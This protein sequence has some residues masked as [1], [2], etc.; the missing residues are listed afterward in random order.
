MSSNFQ[1]VDRAC[2]VFWGRV[3]RATGAQARSVGIFR[4]IY[5][6]Y[7]LALEAPSFTFIDEAPRAFFDPPVLSL[8]FLLDGFP[9]PPFFRILDLFSVLAL[10]LVTIGY[11]TRTAILA[12]FACSRTQTVDLRK[13]YDGL[14]LLSRAGSRSAERRSVPVRGQ[15]GSCTNCA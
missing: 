1:F 13:G 15:A 7:F 12:Q 6:L 10:A 8:A 4:W 3:A 11:R 14:F 5:G 2:A 9:P